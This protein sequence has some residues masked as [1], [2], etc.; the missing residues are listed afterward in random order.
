M[1]GSA[2]GVLHDLPWGSEEN[3]KK[4]KQNIWSSGRDSKPS[5]QF[6]ETAFLFTIP[7]R[8]VQTF[9]P[10][11]KCELSETQNPFA[12][13]VHCND[14]RTVAYKEG[15][16][17]RRELLAGPE[18]VPPLVICGYGTPARRISRATVHSGF[19]ITLD[20]SPGKWQCCVPASL[21]PPPSY[22]RANVE[23]PCVNPNM[24]NDRCS[25]WPWSTVAIM[26]R[27]DIL[28]SQN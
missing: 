9:A 7:R 11:S 13:W 27:A 3:S 20:K 23:V 25:E 15:G 19:C 5:P 12:D 8:S 28:C 2:I 26:K 14:L 6:R 10:H 18:A 21:P 16:N 17:E 24:S 22:L 4:P 1:E